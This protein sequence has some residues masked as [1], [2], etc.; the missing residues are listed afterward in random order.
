[1]PAVITVEKGSIKLASGRTQLGE[2]KLYQVV[3]QERD[4]ETITFKADEEELILTLQEHA[5]F[6]AE[7]E[8][9]RRN[10]KRAQRQMTHEAFRK[11]PEGPTLGE[12]IR[13]DV[14][15]EVNSVVD[16]VKDLFRMV[17][18]GPALW[19]AL[20]VFILLVVFLPSVIIGA[21]FLIGTIA[22]V[23]GALSHADSNIALRL[24]GDFTATRLVALG[25][26]LLG[27]GVILFIVR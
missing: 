24:P 19:A 5:S 15:R 8:A 27:L 20:A 18:P 7:T 23:V 4:A 11:E 17:K 6:L 13:E 12:E 9:Y 16:E 10:E 1:M 22:L 2:W 25:V 3:I 26:I 21:L 14:T